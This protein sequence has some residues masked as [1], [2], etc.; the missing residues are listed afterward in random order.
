MSL[1]QLIGTLHN[2]CKGQG[3]NPEYLTSPYL[4]VSALATRL[5]DIKKIKIEILF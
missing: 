3:L 1:V 2:L 4:I 5:L